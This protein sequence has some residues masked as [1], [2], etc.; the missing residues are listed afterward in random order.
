MYDSRH[1]LRAHA[2]RSEGN[3]VD[4]AVLQTL[5]TGS[6]AKSV[7]LPVT[8]A[9]LAAIFHGVL[10]TILFS[11]D[12]AAIARWDLVGAGAL[13][14]GALLIARDRRL[15]GLWVV[16]GATELLVA[17]LVVALGLDSGWGTSL[18]AVLV[19]PY[20]FFQEHPRHMTAAMALATAIGLV[21]VFV[22][23]RT[24]APAGLDASTLRALHSGNV[25]G[26]I[27]LFAATGVLIARSS[28]RLRQRLAELRQ[29]SATLE[30]LGQYT[31]GRVLGAGA[32]GTVYVASHA[33]LK[34]PAALKVINNREVSEEMRTLF[35]QEVEAT[36]A[37]RSPHTI[38][39]YDFGQ[40]E[41]GE[42]YYVMEML[43]GLTL[44]ELVDRHGAIPANRAIYVLEQICHS[45]AE[46]HARGIAHRDIKPANIQLCRYG[47]DYDFIKVLDFGLAWDF[48]RPDL[49][50]ARS[51]VVG[52][53]AYVAPE[54]ALGNADVD[55]RADIYSLG[56]VAFWLLTGSRVFPAETPM[57]NLTAHVHLPPS[58]PSEVSELEIPP[59][60]DALVLQCLSKD[61]NARPPDAE[62]LRRGLRAIP[63]ARAWD[64]D[65]AREWWQMHRPDTS[66]SLVDQGGCAG[67]R[68]GN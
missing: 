34:R 35:E 65:D 22:A 68:A 17:G 63:L 33:F 48:T 9:L 25:A 45:L 54:L 7:W 26:T 32:M 64:Q 24:E 61:P 2:L 42:L 37:L 11:L 36:A 46:A 40:S 20:L 14:V 60:L 16:F 30:R 51:E 13:L 15:V 4:R 27:V 52:T 1:T 19:F 49:S 62:A 12:R 50:D 29:R 31:L 57:Q 38:E 47:K 53:P 56:C 43:D 3:R 18:V 66:L 6:V 39:V 10:A 55:G 41:A 67:P 44:Q 28:S 59:E 23:V 5:Q 21:A 58:A 8:L